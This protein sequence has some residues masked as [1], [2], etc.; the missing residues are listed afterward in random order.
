LKKNPKSRLGLE[1][2]SELKIGPKPRINFWLELDPKL[3]L[4]LATKL[5]LYS[6]WLFIFLISKL[7]L[8]AAMHYW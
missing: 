1:L 3:E 8:C 7:G 4:E 2:D 5:V 6:F